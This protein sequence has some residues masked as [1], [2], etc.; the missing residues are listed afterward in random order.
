MHEDLEWHDG[1]R[2]SDRHRVGRS[3]CPDGFSFCKPLFSRKRQFLNPYLVLNERH[4]VYGYELLDG[5][6]GERFSIRNPRQYHELP[7]YLHRCRRIRQLLD[8]GNGD[9]AHVKH[10]DAL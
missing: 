1:E 3:S 6:R 8:D 9:G 5:K 4:R 2:V 10:L 7:G